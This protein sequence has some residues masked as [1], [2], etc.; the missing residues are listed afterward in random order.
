MNMG[1]KSW[2]N[3]PAG[4]RPEL[5]R[6]TT[7]ILGVAFSGTAPVKRVEVSTDG[8]RSWRE[9][10]F[11]GPDLGRFAW[12]QFALQ[13]DLPAGRY[14]LASRATD[15]AGNVQ[16]EARVENLHG[17]NNNSWSDHAVSVTVA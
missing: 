6:G 14:T 2:I 7:Q 3:A 17:Y 11:I 13:V 1:V 12:R 8:G 10:K 15:A 4:D 9:A 5:S 16:P